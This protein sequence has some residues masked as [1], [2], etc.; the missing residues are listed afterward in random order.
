MD[1]RETIISQYHSA[2][3]MLEQTIVACPEGLWHSPGDG[4][5]FWQ[6]AYRSHAQRMTHEQI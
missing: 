4:N 3:E 2:L 6:G 1:I 5:K